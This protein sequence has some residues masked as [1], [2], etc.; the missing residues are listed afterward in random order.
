MTPGRHTPPS[1]VVAAYKYP[2]RVWFEKEVPKGPTGK[3]LRREIKPPPREAAS[4][5]H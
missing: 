5:A 1:A 4:T 3:I 2:R